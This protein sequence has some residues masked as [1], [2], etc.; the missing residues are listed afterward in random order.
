MVQVFAIDLRN[1][2][3][4]A[5]KVAGELEEGDV[6]FANGVHDA[7]GG[8]IAAGEAKDGAAGAA[9]L[10]LEGLRAFRGRVEM[11]L[12]EPLQYVHEGLSGDDWRLVTMVWA[13]SQR[14]AA[15][16]SVRKANSAEWHGFATALGS[17]E[18]KPSFMILGSAKGWFARRG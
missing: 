6:L 3:S 17:N 11:L 15:G 2:Q 10:A 14:Y 12:E 7:D 5:A 16:G 18:W 9:E 4:V 13:A 8:V 1:G